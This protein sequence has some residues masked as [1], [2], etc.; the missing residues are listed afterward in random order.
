M[1]RKII[2]NDECGWPWPRGVDTIKLGSIVGKQT[3]KKGIMSQ[4]RVMAL[5]SH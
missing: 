2:W 3:K 5:A 1:G 4:H